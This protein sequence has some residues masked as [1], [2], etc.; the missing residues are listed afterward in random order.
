MKKV[1]TR[2]II[3]RRELSQKGNKT[4]IKIE[5]L[6]RKTPNKDPKKVINTISKQKKKHKDYKITAEIMIVLNLSPK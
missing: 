4:A 6:M 5:R 3:R 2:E 1:K